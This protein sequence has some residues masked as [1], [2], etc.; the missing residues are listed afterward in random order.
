MRICSTRSEVSSR[1]ARTTTGPIRGFCGVPET[2]EC[3]SLGGEDANRLGTLVQRYFLEGRFGSITWS[4]GRRDR[5][6]LCTSGRLYARSRSR[7]PR[8]A[9]QEPIF[10]ESE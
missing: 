2:G 8:S 7:S 10:E 1:G 6:E 5:S 3:P 9:L 4:P